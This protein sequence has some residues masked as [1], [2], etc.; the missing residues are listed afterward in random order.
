M[1]PPDPPHSTRGN[2]VTSTLFERSDERDAYNDLRPSTRNSTTGENREYVTSDR[3]I[4]TSAT[5]N[6]E[7]DPNYKIAGPVT[8]MA[9]VREL[10]WRNSVSGWNVV[11][12]MNGATISSIDTVNREIDPTTALSVSVISTSP[13]RPTSV[14]GANVVYLMNGAPSEVSM[15]STSRSHNRGPRRLQRRR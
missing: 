13:A 6:F 1:S 8:S 14:S 3:S 5:V 11:Y 10:F 4:T 2:F 15:S 9:T 12:I 7:I